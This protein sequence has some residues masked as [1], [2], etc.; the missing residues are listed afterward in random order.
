MLGIFKDQLVANPEVLVALLEYSPL[1][2]RVVEMLRQFAAKG[3]AD[4]QSQQMKNLQIAKIVAGINKDQSTAE[5]QDAK[6]GASQATAAY[7]VAMAQHLLTKGDFDQLG[8]HLAHM[9]TASEIQATQAQTAHTQAQMGHTHAK[10]LGEHASTISTMA[11]DQ[12]DGEDG[13]MASSA[14]RVRGGTPEMAGAT[15]FVGARRARDGN[16]Y[17]PDP[18]RPGKFV[19]LVPQQS[20]V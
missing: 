15:P 12:G 6:A 9:K 7:D 2:N 17:S 3:A 14:S 5:M 1:P 8:Q 10:T 11:G 13:A 20:A 4:P 19:M 18:N 16:L